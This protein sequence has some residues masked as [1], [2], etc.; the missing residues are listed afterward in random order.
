[1]KNSFCDAAVNSHIANYIE[2]VI[3]AMNFL[4]SILDKHDEFDV[5]EFTQQCSFLLICRTLLGIDV[6]YADIDKKLFTALKE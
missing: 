2:S 4:S 3:K 1:M 5:F 6:N